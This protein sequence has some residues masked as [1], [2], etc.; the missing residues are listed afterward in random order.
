MKFSEASGRQVVSSNTAETVGQV[1]G[2]VI[3][4]QSHSVVAITLKRT[5]HGDTVLWADLTAFG[6]D[7]VTVPDAEVI[8]GANDAVAALSGKDHRLTG[9]RIL[10]TDGQDLGA[11]K[12][13]DF[14]P[15]TGRL[16]ELLLTN[17]TVR[18]EHLI[19]IG[20]YAAIVH[21]DP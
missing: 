6:V 19:G 12:D 7:A 21:A 9:K 2:F 11:V 5:E 16:T 17:H 13:A 15:T 10:N 3:D 4:P 18:G 20:S 1:A 8:L 14:D